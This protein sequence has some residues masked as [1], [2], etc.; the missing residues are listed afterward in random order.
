MTVFSV[1][2][3]AAA[4]AGVWKEDEGAAALFAVVSAA[5]AAAAAFGDGTEP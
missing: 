4:M 5:A 1:A 2:A 3:D